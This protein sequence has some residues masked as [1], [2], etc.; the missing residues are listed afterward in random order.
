MD[1]ANVDFKTVLTIAHDLVCSVLLFVIVIKQGRQH[2]QNT[3]RMAA[4]ESLLARR[5]D[6]NAGQ[7]W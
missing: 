6:Q 7:R 1:I 3:E 4:I 2:H 5:S